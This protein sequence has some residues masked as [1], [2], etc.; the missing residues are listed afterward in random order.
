MTTADEQP[1]RLFYGG[2]HSIR[3]MQQQ[4]YAVVEV[5]VQTMSNRRDT[6]RKTAGRFRIRRKRT[7]RS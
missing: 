4:E 6:Q 3:M 1:S 7:D 2:I 5:T